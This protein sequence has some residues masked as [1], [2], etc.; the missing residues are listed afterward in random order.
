M[1]LI[2][3]FDG[4]IGDTQSLI[5]KTLQQTISRLRLPKR[6]DAEC[7]ATIGLPLV[8]AFT[9]LFGID[10]RQ[11][12]HCAEVYSEIFDKNNVPNAVQMFPHVYDTI[13]S[14]HDEGVRFTIAS[15]RHRESIVK[16]LDEMRLDGFIEYIVSASDVTNAKPAPEM[17]LK[18]LKHLNVSPSEA[19]VVGDT[20]FDIE[21]AHRAGVKAI[22]VTYGN[23]TIDDMK[24]AGA[25]WT[26]DDFGMVK[27]VLK[28]LS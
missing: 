7:A 18:T 1:I 9:T 10:D 20:R 4:T 3:D 23:G 11:G 24:Q 22:G 21:M 14:L 26:V 25:D 19:I 12:E 28:S 15:S 16:Y 13:A 2:L 6:T 27:T 17:V 5:V 8:K